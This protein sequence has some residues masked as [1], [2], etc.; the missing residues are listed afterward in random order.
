LKKADPESVD[1]QRIKDLKQA[2]KDYKAM[3]I[4]FNAQ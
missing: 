2:R 4:R 1:S 3:L